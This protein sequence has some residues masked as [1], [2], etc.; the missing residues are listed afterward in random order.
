LKHQQAVGSVHRRDR[1]FILPEAYSR[2]S[3]P[4]RFRPIQH[5]GLQL[6]EQ[7][8][9]EFSVDR[10]DGADL[11]RQLETVTTDRPTILL[12]P[13]SRNAAP[14]LFVFTTLPGV[15]L[16]FG[17][18]PIAAFPTCGCDACG[19]L[20]NPEIDRMK[21]LV[22]DV[23]AG[24]FHESIRVGLT[25]RPVCSW[26]LWSAS[27]RQ[28]GSWEVDRTLLRETA[29]INGSATGISRLW[30]FGRRTDVEWAPW[31]RGV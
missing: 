31:P 8:E 18:Y 25:G 5:A 20:P 27:G 11:P 6:I 14:L 12:S 10:F 16:R 13:V 1:N 15:L 23:V 28:S 30:P 29:K 21:S 22:A 4:E 24:R 2:M 19:A 9:R 7:L 17:R 26:A 3:N